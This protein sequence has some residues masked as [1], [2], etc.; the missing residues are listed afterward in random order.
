MNKLQ[1]IGIAV[2]LGSAA[3]STIHIINKII[4][5]TSVVNGVTI[6]NNKLN[7]KWKFG[8]ISYT[9][10]GKGKPILL[11]HDLKNTSSSYE[12]NKIIQK[13]SKNRTVYAIDL[14]GCG[15]SDKPNITYTAYL[16]VQLLNDF[17]TNVIGK[18]TDVVVTG[19]SCPMV[20]MACYNNTTL[21]DKLILL[22]PESIGRSTQIPNK[23][24]NLFRILLN[25][26]VI[27]TMIYNV[28]MSKYNI[29]KCF[30]NDLFYN[31]NH[32]SK[33]VLN[34]YHENAHLYGS[35]AKFLYTS[36]KC[37]YTTASIGRA[38]SEINNCIYIIGGESEPD[39]NSTIEDYISINPAI[40]F[41]IINKCR[42]L[43]QLEQ[44]HKLISQ[45]DIFL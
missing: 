45:L 35:S 19:D 37:R 15:Y 43:P 28:C 44:P 14:L 17:I 25:S 24:S 6:I 10:S 1:K 18:R 21:F 8:N 31:Y 9:K 33:D 13:L 27:G 11:I 20:I 12:W 16:Y 5:S 3:I 32:I 7:Y 38:I 29:R 30:Q 26:P 36:T 23:K 2:G 22:N 34:A 42:H 40:E 41:S 4:F 39:M